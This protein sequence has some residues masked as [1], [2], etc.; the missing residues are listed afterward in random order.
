[1]LTEDQMRH[2]LE[3]YAT[4]RER[5]FLRH[6][7]PTS[8]LTARSRAVYH[9]SSYARQGDHGHETSIRSHHSSPART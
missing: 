8:G 1:M 9:T 4:E 2:A 5:I 3:E 7:N 6:T